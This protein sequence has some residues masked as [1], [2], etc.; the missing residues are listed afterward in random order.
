MT[1]WLNHVL[2]L[3]RGQV[4]RNLIMVKP[5]NAG[6]GPVLHNY[7]NIN[8][9]SKLFKLTKEL[10][11]VLGDKLVKLSTCIKVFLHLCPFYWHAKKFQI[12]R[13]LT[14][15]IQHTIHSYKL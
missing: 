15:L 7:H 12:C 11:P 13:H 6:E 2:Y 4:N 10:T 5:W 3:N 1:I 14:V 8:N 9:V